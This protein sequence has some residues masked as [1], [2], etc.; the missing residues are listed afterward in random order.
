[1]SDGGV[2]GLTPHRVLWYF[3][4][5]SNRPFEIPVPTT[6]QRRADAPSASGGHADGRKKSPASTDRA[7]PP[8]TAAGSHHLADSG[9]GADRE[10]ADPVDSA[11][12]SVAGPG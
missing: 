1:M 12:S 7:G 3:A 11:E 6:A 10:G 5:Q 2:R 8:Q 9:T 4:V